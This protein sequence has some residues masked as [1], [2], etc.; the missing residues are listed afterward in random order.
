M[1][2]LRDNK[3][4]FFRRLTPGERVRLMMKHAYEIQCSSLFKPK[5]EAHNESRSN[6]LVVEMTKKQTKHAISVFGEV[7]L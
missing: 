5:R 1:N 6:V 4:A 3:D 7:M 2:L